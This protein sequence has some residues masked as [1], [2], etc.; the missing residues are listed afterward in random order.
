MKTSQIFVFLILALLVT[1]S[2]TADAQEPLPAYESYFNYIETM[3]I[4]AETSYSHEAQGIAHD[5]GNWFISQNVENVLVSSP[6]LWKIPK[7]L[8]LADTFDCGQFGV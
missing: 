2:G 7:D 3:P 4:D 8:N 5:S 6:K 1:L